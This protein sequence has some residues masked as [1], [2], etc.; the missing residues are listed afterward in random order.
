M[1]G[2]GKRK[3][4][5]FLIPSLSGGGAERVFTTLLRHLDRTRFEPHLALLEATGAYTDDIPADIVVHDLK[6]KRVRY[7]WPAIIRLVRKI[8]PEAILSTPG[9]LNIAIAMFRFLLPRKLKVLV[10]EAVIVSALLPEETSHLGLWTWLYRYAYRRADLVICL[11]DSMIDDMVK[12]I[13]LPPHKLHRIYN[14]VDL[15][16]LRQQTASS[17]NPYRGPGPHL[18]AAG[19]LNH[20]KGFDVLLAAMPIVVASLPSARLTVLGEGPLLN[21]LQEQSQQLGLDDVVCFAGFSNSPW[22]YLKHADVFVLPSRYEGLSNVMLEAIALG[23]PVV[24]TD[25]P[26]AVREVCNLLG[27]ITLVPVEDS[28]SLAEAVIEAAGV[29]GARLRTVQRD[30]GAFDLRRIVEEYSD[31]F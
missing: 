28:R 5:L 14:P 15:E 1:S 13:G 24:A 2:L 6:V 9:H 31:T 26:G 29:N 21:A 12:E 27:G 19:R 10:R 25:C 3:K 23:T 20:Q 7:A 4:V 30:M 8:R 16:R 18:V 22:T 11:S 17:E